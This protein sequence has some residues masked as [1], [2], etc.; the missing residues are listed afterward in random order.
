MIKGG[1]IGVI[2]KKDLLLSRTKESIPKKA[3]FFMKKMIFKKNKYIQSS[4][5]EIYGSFNYQLQP[6]PSDVDSTNIVK[7]KKN[8]SE[9]KAIKISAITIQNIV[10]KI[11]KIKN[12]TISDLKC[13]SHDNSEPIHWSLDDILKGY[14]NANKKDKN[15][16]S[17]KKKITLI[18]ALTDIGQIC[19]LDL[20]A[21]FMGRYVEIT[22]LYQIYADGVPITKSLAELDEQHINLLADTLTQFKK[23]K[24]FKIIKR[25]FSY[26]RLTKNYNLLK[27]LE[28]FINS[29][30]SKL[31]SFKS[32][33][34][35]LGLIIENDKFPLPQ[36]T[37]DE[38][39]KIKFGIDNILDMDINKKEVYNQIDILKDFIKNKNKNK[40]LE[41]LKLINKYFD[42]VIN[43]E[44]NIYLG[45]KGTKQLESII[46][47]LII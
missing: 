20:I 37:N 17:S 12:Y 8:I 4:E 31:A 33:L 16:N 45:K 19:K 46:D 6:F 30:L 36:M 35:T 10:K 28:P 9:D 11:S 5:F 27:F 21:P 13:G 44:T 43:H 7:F 25:L 14:I 34:E 2:K 15:G 42:K 1:D 3:E 22:V 29:N 24:L 38:L 41:K 47:K 40:S 23:G 39:D 26:A 32:D 18:D